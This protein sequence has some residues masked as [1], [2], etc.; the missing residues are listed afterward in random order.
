MKYEYTHQVTGK[1]ETIN[2]TEGDII[3]MM[4]GI[5]VEI[6]PNDTMRGL[7]NGQPD[8]KGWMP[9]PQQAVKD[10]AQRKMMGAA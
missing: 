7:R 4:P 10:L 9:I 1:Q 6:G 5:S 2:L 3:K 8:P